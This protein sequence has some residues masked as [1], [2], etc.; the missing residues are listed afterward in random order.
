MSLLSNSSHF[1]CKYYLLPSKLS[2]ALD[3]V[4]YYKI[5][6]KHFLQ[7]LFKTLLNYYYKLYLM[8]SSVYNF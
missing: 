7:A 6:W 8:T 4:I 3:Q 5:T 2:R 1:N